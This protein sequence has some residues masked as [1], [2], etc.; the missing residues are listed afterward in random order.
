MNGPL[1]PTSLHA[2][3]APGSTVPQLGP[4]PTGWEPG[5][6]YEPN[7][8]RIVTTP[9]SP[10][11]EDYANLIATMGVTV[12]D[13]FR[14]RLVEAKYDPAAWHRDQEFIR[15]AERDGQMTKAPAVTR[16]VWRYQFVVEVAPAAVNVDE[17]LK[18]IKPRRSSSKPS[19]SLPIGMKPAT[20]VY[21]VG[22]PQIG[23]PD[24]DGS[25]ATVQRF[26]DSLDRAVTHYKTRRKRFGA[27][28]VLLPWLGDCVEGTQSQGGR[29][30]G[31]LDL[32]LTEQI[33]VLRRLAAEQVTAFADLADHVTVAAVP[34]NH[35]EALRVGDQMAS[36]YDDSWDVEAL[37]QVAD[38]LAAKGYDNVS[39]LFPERDQL[40]VTVDASGTRVGL[41]HGHQVR[42]TMESW[43]G[44]KALDRDPIGTCDVIL[45]GHKHT[46]RVEHLGP[47]TWMQTGALDGGSTW[48]TH[49]GGLSS[50]PAALTFI[51]E[52][53]RWSGLEVV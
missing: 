22:D 10:E 1:S 20:F 53:G 25:E 35:G 33:R 23:K 44:A 18:S 43:L 11:T 45:S 17:L 13:G 41:L 21:A 15:R 24:G 5:V 46:L 31:R 40:T 7:G 32:T 6:K 8:S 47:T 12:P 2:L 34:G 19:S 37:V 38:V 4:T 51:T 42:K 30:V 50:P 36:R 29:L 28:P 14:V 52:G 48:W 3:A 16:P 27:L 49:K 39:W 9:P 26:L